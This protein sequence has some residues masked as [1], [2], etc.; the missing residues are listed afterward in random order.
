MSLFMSVFS[1]LIPVITALVVVLIIIY[2]F[3]KI[4]DLKKKWKFFRNAEA[5]AEFVPKNKLF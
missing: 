2:L 5:E 1:F 3:K 4:L